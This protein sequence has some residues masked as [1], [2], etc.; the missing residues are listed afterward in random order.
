[1]KKS[2]ALFLL[3]VLN[4]F[5]LIASDIVIPLGGNAWS[6]A[7]AVITDDGLTNWRSPQSVPAIYFK[8][9]QPQ[10][11]DLYLRLK[12]TS[13]KST[14]SVV[15][16]NKT[17]RINANNTGFDTIAVGRITVS[18]AEH[19]KVALKG[20]SKTGAVY[21]DISDLIIKGN[22]VDSTLTYVRPGSSYH[23]GR[24]GPS[25]HLN[26]IVPDEMKNDV[27]WFYSEINVPKGN[28][29][30]GSYFM[31]DGFGEGYF[32]MQVNSAKERRVL[33]SVW[34]P[35]ETDDPKNIP[36]S[37]KI[38]LL[39]KGSTVHAQAF[40]DEGSGGQSYMNYMWQAGRTYGFLLN[41]KPDS[42]TASTTFTAWFKDGSTGKW[43]LVASFSRP[44]TVKYLSHLYSFLENFEPENGDKTRMAIYKNQWVANS[45]GQW[46]S[47]DQ[48]IY[49][50]DATAN[51]N[52]RKD[53]AGGLKADGFYLMNCGFFNDF[54]PLKRKFEKQPSGNKP[55]IP[56]S[57]LNGR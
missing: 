7:P 48:I 19:V 32:G 50:G 13:G 28:D 40:G 35:F 21:A 14:I 53:Y 25:V 37:L 18:Q 1:M 11:L 33:F 9:N 24:R 34:S 31:A 45:K 23:F 51:A 47:L 30:V 42:A 52:Y 38:K 44:K 46:K 6:N 10:S 29:I 49:T 15:V 16:N 17:F 41:A 56:S 26:Y 4:T 2:A 57:I 3:A 22:I 39:K 43:Q 5:R 12:V 36:D 27:R 8:V 54:V 55:V 20:L